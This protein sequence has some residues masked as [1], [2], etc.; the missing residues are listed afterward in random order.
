MVSAPP[1]TRPGRSASTSPA[2]CGA[3]LGAVLPDGVVHERA[4]LLPDLL[5]AR[6]RPPDWIRE[7]AEKTGVRTD[8]KMLLTKRYFDAYPAFFAL[9]VWGRVFGTKTLRPKLPG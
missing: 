7:L 1:R 5:A 9:G 2:A 8:V 3:D 6:K 4:E